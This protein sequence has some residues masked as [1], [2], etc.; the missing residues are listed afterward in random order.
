MN[1]GLVLYSQDIENL[2]TFYTSCF[3]FQKRDHDSSYVRLV[4]QEIELVILKSPEK[5]K[6]KEIKP[7][8]DTP[9]KPVYFIST[10]LAAIRTLIQSNGGFFKPSDSEWQFNNTIVCDGYDT[11]GNIFQVRCCNAI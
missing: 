11:E 10:S 3:G 2:S 9:I 1:L 6:T 4:N 5:Y 7:R 8:T